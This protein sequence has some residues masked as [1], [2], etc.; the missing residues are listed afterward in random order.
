MRVARRGCVICFGLVC[1]CELNK[2]RVRPA[3]MF[4]AGQ[5]DGA[6]WHAKLDTHKRVTTRTQQAQPSNKTCARARALH[7][8]QSLRA[9]R[10]VCAVLGAAEV[11]Q[12]LCERRCEIA[13][14]LATRRARLSCRAC[15]EPCSSRCNTHC[16]L[17]ARDCCEQRSRPLA[18]GA[19]EAQ[20]ETDVYGQHD[21]RQRSGRK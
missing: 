7:I 10:G 14:K 2:L 19:R 16:N 17:M 3:G 12:A 4:R 6:L 20:T 9:V 8:V 15:F 21:E 11:F 18:D 1:A 13:M 5:F